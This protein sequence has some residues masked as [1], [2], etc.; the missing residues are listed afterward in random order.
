MARL[1]QGL[2]A[3]KQAGV[4]YVCFTGGEPLLYPELLPALDRA[5]DLG[6]NTILCTNGSLLTPETI[7]EL[8]AAALETLII[9]MDAPSAAQHDRHR[10]LPGLTDHIRDLLPLLRRQGL[11]P[12]A[13]VTLSRMVDDLEGMIHFLAAWALSGS[14]FLT[15]S[16]G[17]TPPTWGSPTTIPWISP[18]KNCTAG[19]AASKT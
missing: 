1:L 3:L 4:Q 17:C 16:P 6:I 12:V 15:P 7:E 10:G 8:K 18:R 5:R 11:D 14:P 13:S 2:G 19:L 9:S